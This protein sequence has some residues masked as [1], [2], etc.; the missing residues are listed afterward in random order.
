MK[1]GTMK[2]SGGKVRVYTAGISPGKD[3][4]PAKGPGPTRKI[5]M[6]K[7]VP[8]AKKGA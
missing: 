6:A 4:T 5:G 1:T 8:F 3:T 7:G 2:T